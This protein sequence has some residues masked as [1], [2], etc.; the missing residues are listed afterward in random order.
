MLAEWTPLSCRIPPKPTY[1]GTRYRIG[2]STM[3]GRTIEIGDPF[4]HSAHEMNR[5]ILFRDRWTDY[6]WNVLPNGRVDDVLAFSGGLHQ[7]YKGYNAETSSVLLVRMVCQIGLRF[8]G[9]IVLIGPL[10]I[11][12]QRNSRTDM[13]DGNILL[14]NAILRQTLLGTTTSSGGASLGN[15]CKAAANDTSI[16]DNL[17]TTHGTSMMRAAT[18]NTF[19]RIHRHRNTTR[20]ETNLIN[21][22]QSLTTNEID[23]LY[24]DRTVLFAEL[25]N[26]IRP[27]PETYVENDKIHDKIQDKY[28]RT[29]L[30]G[31]H[32]QLIRD[33]INLRAMA[34]PWPSCGY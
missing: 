27:R 29:L 9:K 18:T 10:P 23:N 2:D 4:H 15:L 34:S 20:Q 32:Q 33:L 1:T 8:K 28:G 12:Q 13:R 19:H 14:L 3:P 26:V 5:K 7:L 16:F 24:G 11:Q 21:Y 22:I 31:K 25:H 17:P 6:L 30:Y